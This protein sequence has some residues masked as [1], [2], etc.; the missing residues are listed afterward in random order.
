MRTALI[1]GD[2]IAYI[3]GWNFRD[4][5]DDENLMQ[6]SI[7]NFVK[8][9]FEV[10]EATHYIGALSSNPT[11]RHDV[12]RYA[13]Y[14]GTRGQEHD[15][16]K[17]WKPFINNHLREDWGFVSIKALEADDIVGYHSYNDALGERIVCSPDKDLAQLPGKLY[18]YQTGVMTTIDNQSAEENHR[19][20]MVCGDITDNIKGI[21]GLGPA[22]L[23]KKDGMSVYDM[24]VEYFGTYYGTI[25]HEETL[26]TVTVMRP[27]HTYESFFEQQLSKLVALEVPGEKDSFE[28]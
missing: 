7:D 18:N 5:L 24:Y 27:G 16:I 20:L 21:P 11:F 2:S 6:Y 9:I 17:R 8:S 10:L 13:K 28:E 3:L 14:K 22:K 23:K 25:I 12:Y 19:V 15:A 4:M 1:D 26:A